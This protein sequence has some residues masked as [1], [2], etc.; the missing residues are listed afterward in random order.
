MNA[1]LLHASQCFLGEGPCWHPRRNSIFWVDIENRRLYEYDWPNGAHMRHWK[2][3]QR[4]TLVV[5]DKDDRLILGM[6]DGVMRFDPDTGESHWLF[7]LEKEYKKH[8]CN[9]G[10][11][12]REGRLWV[13]TLH[14]DFIPGSGALYCIG[15]DL[16]PQKRIADV[17]ISNGIAW[18]ED[19]TR[20]YFIDSPQKTIASYLY[21][22]HTGHLV[23]EKI[24][25]RI[26]EGMG[27]PDGMTIDE[28]GMLWVAHWGGYGVYRWDPRTDALLD[29]I[30]VPVPNVSSCVFAGASLDHLVITTA[31]QDLTPQQLKE[32]PHSGDVFVVQPQVKGTPARR[33]RL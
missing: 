17:T 10:S 32:Y 22:K 9:D 15:E 20:L 6:E 19:D 4:V 33:C 25:V 12:D 18:S 2:F 27:E 24:A 14:R 28:E 13:G 3:P 8:R 26:P 11:V 16:A 29:V 5:I 31:Q 7:D 1:R 23:F 30:K 21:D